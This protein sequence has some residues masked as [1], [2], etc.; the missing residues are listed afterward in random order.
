MAC[1]CPPVP[2]PA[3]GRAERWQCGDL[4]RQSFESRVVE[5][6]FPQVKHSIFGDASFGGSLARCPQQRGRLDAASVI[7]KPVTGRLEPWQLGSAKHVALGIGAQRERAQ[8]A[9]HGHLTPND[10]VSVVPGWFLR[11]I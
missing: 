4:R 11:R 1:L 7:L 6:E 9:S 3:A 8:A 10:D 5:I 2:G